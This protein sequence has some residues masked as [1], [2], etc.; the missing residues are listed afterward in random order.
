MRGEHACV[1][2]DDLIHRSIEAYD[3]NLLDG[4]VPHPLA[5][6]A[7]PPSLPRSLALVPRKGSDLETAWVERCRGPLETA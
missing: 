4:D 5:P 6:P 1:R 7:L 3:L 2:A